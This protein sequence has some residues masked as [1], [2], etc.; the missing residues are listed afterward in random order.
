M[1]GGAAVGKFGEMGARA[2]LAECGADEVEEAGRDG[3]R[4][5][6]SRNVLDAFARAELFGAGVG[7]G[8][9]SLQ[10]QGVEEFFGAAAGATTLGGEVHRDVEDDGE[11]RDQSG[12]VERGNPR[13]RA[14]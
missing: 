9:A 6:D 1:P 2:G 14:R 12:A 11:I 3:F 10:T 13:A 7:F 5:P 4:G 8:E